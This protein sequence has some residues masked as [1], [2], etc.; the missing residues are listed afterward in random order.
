MANYVQ[1]TATSPSV[2]PATSEIVYDKYWLSNMRIEA[3]DSTKP[4]KLVALFTPAR[5]VSIQIPKKDAEGK[6]IVDEQGSPVMEIFYYKETMPNAE[7]KKLVIQDLFAEAEKNPQ[8]LG[9]A[10]NVVLNL[11]NGLAQEKGIL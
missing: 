6:P 5:D 3:Q 2:K 7:P 8:V 4:V 11:L 9:A 10:M 1:F